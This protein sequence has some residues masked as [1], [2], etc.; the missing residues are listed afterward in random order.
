MAEKALKKVEDQLN[1]SICLETY[2]SPKLLQCFHVYCLHCIQRLV[3]RDKDG[4]LV[5]PC[6]TCR[7]QTLIPAGG[8]SG[9]QSAFHINHLLDIMDEH[10]RIKELS[11]DPE[12]GKVHAVNPPNSSKMA[13][14]HLCPVHSEEELKLYCATC[15]ELVCFKCVIKGEPHQQ[16]EYELLDKA[17]EKYKEEIAQ[18]VEPM[19]EQL[20]SIDESLVQLEARCVEVTDQHTLT[21]S[22]I[23]KGINRLQTVLDARRDQLTSQLYRI[24]QGKLKT[25]A[26]QKDEMEMA[27]VQ[28]RSSVNFM[29]ESL[30]TCSVGE[31]LRM[32]MAIIKQAKGLRNSFQTDMLKP[33]A[34]ADMQFSSSEEEAT[35][36]CQNYGNV[37]APNSPNPADC[38][39]TG[40]GTKEGV[41]GEKSVVILGAVNFKGEPCK[42]PLN[43]LECKLVS[44]L[45]DS[46]VKGVVETR[47]QSGCDI[48][49]HPLVKGWHKLHVQIDG[50]HVKGSPFA[51]TV[52]SPVEKLGAP[53]L[54]KDEVKK[55]WGIAVNRKGEV[56]VTES[57]QHCVSVFSPKGEKMWSFGSYGSRARQF[58]SPRG[59]AVDGEGNIMVADCYNHRIQKFT[60]E[61]HAL[62]TA[63][64]EGGKG[65]W[66]PL[67][68]HCPHGIAYS[69]HNN[70]VY[71]VDCN[72]HVQIL[73]SDLTYYSI[74]GRAGSGR[75]HFNYPYAVA[76]DSAGRVYIA[77]KHNHRVQV[78]T[79]EGKFVR[80]FGEQGGGQGDL[81]LPVGVAVDANAMVYVSEMTNFRVSVFTADGRFVTAFGGEGE[82][83]GKFKVV[84]GVAVDG[85]GVVY[86]CDYDN[87]C[88]KAF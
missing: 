76:C 59:V 57:N 37:R 56:I 67:Q 69:S 43:T 54:T 78:F 63:G 48:S 79:A 15:G 24:T 46:S 66:S 18:C 75:G 25:L 65:S 23:T 14:L 35:D 88:Y 31:I 45:T 5:L 3:D 28:V 58:K 8:V 20:A 53:I 41:V 29:K 10:K 2:S 51:V 70:K 49:Y 11:T 82:G 32:K 22:N 12:E 68:F 38:R 13:L 71:V 61:G 21:E 9:L 36:V 42:E 47:G 85:S 86:V 74:F 60:A 84:A 81:S 83:P 6:P 80:M 30:E 87:H 73:N 33:N 34:A 39:L 72:N 52:K 7:Y 26:T 16:H 55:P 40:R 4:K 19:E 17:F 62:T 1:C 44:E 27:Q 77:D 50:R 64:T